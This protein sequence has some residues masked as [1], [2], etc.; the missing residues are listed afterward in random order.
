MI[1][2]VVI[3]LVLGSP[4]MLLFAALGPVVAVASAIDS[5]RTAR[6][7]D[8]REG[9]RFEHECSLFERAV[10]D[11]H[12]RERREAELQHPAAAHAAGET[13]EGVRIGRA[14]DRSVV[15]SD[16]A[17]PLGDTD[18]HERI[19]RM[20]AHAQRNPDLPAL[21]V[22]GP[23]V[24]DGHGLVADGIARRLSLVPGVT[25]FRRGDDD[26]LPANVPVHATVMTVLSATALEVRD[27]VGAV[28]RV[29]PEFVTHRQWLQNR[30]D[31]PLANAVPDSV[32]WSSVQSTNPAGAADEGIPIGIGESGVVTID[33]IRSGPHALIGGTT[34]SGKSE[35][36]RSLALGWAMRFSPIAA[37]ILFVDFKGG[38]TFAG[39]T[40]LPHSVGLVTDLN[41]L[42]AQRALRALRAELQ[43]RE[44]TLAEAGVRD[45]RDDPSLLPRLLVLVDEFA[46]LASTFPELHGVFADLAAR[47]RSLGVH[48]VLCTQHPASV[49]RDAVAANCPVRLSFRVTEAASAGIVGDRARELVSA[50]PGRAVLVDERGSQVLQVAVVGADDRHRVMERWREHPPAARTWCDPLPDR[51]RPEELPPNDRE[52]RGSTIDEITFGLLDDPDNRRRVPAVWRPPVDGTLAVVGASSSGR[53]TALAALAEGSG[54][55]GRVVMLPDAL[56]DAWAVLEH[57]AARTP[58]ATLLLCDRLDRLALRSGDR[59]NELLTR[60]DAAVEALRSS[61]GAAAA[62]LASSSA[63]SSLVTGRFESRL[64]LRCADADEHVVAGGP[65]GLFDRSAPPGRGWWRDRQVQVVDPAQQAISPEIVAVPLWRPHRDR[66]TVIITSSVAEI[67]DRIESLAPRHRIVRE[68]STIDPRSIEGPARANDATERHETVVLESRLLIASPA[69]WQAAWALLSAARAQVAI[70]AIGVSESEV[71][72]VLGSRDTLPPIDAQRGECWLAEPGRPMA[73]ARWYP[74]AP[75]ASEP[76]APSV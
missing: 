15:A 22:H 67:I 24:L 69:A 61:G 4:F 75:I 64:I 60:W 33:L 47:G 36:L 16:T 30:V 51:V 32:S 3:G 43:H 18:H 45:I 23:V 38:A 27:A 31:A 58:A 74:V 19:R 66:D 11:A 13:R 42:L 65:R 12:D 2:A 6:R 49:V 8:R 37:Q 52:R 59:S 46:T 71:R 70:V 53:S 26:E 72:T 25:V 14:P 17:L 7:H 48:L 63:A 68:L 76:S 56:A 9:E 5:R 73:R 28:R 20:L 40:E 41:P 55:G 54:F 57:L 1:G 10:H 62:T 29:R 34:G 39:L 35:L 50:P 21:I 44:R